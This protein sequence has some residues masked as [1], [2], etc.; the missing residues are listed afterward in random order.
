[1]SI[2]RTTY[3]C[4]TVCIYIFIYVVATLFVYSNL[5]LGLQVAVVKPLMSRP[6]NSELYLL[7]LDFRGIRSPLLR[8]LCS[9]VDSFREDKAIIPREW[10]PDV[11]L[12]SSCTCLL[13]LL[14]V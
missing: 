3:V 13:L 9:A 1:M 11:S 14:L 7:G 5:I 12:L 10:L 6:G 8:A 4:I 2:S